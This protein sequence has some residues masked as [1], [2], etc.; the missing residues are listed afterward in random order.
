MP[1]PES[2]SNPEP[3][4]LRPG[5]PPPAP[6]VSVVVPACNAKQWIRDAIDSALGQSYA[7]LQVIVVDDGSTDGTGDVLKERYGDAIEYVG[8]AHGGLSRAR[9]TG[10]I[11]ARGEYVQFLDADD[12][13][14]P[15]KISVQ[16]EAFKEHPECAVVFSDFE[17]FDDGRPD[18][19][20][21]GPEEF[22][23]K[24]RDADTFAGLLT[25]NFILSATPLAR[26]AAVVDAGM[27]DERLSACEDFDL[28]LRI[29]ARGGRF[30]FVDRVLAFIRRRAGSMS[31]ARVRQLS[32]TIEVHRRMGHLGRR[33]TNEQARLARQHESKLHEELAAALR[34]EHREW[35][36]ARHVWSAIGCAPREATRILA[37]TYLGA[38][39]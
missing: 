5:A 7:P 3:E 33:L 32:N 28:W 36:A 38:P 6:L 31:T 9:N 26:K 24:S 27:F 2:A 1:P 25:G 23:R 13:L 16:V 20:R 22:R 18:D 15:D 8:Q 19:R 4:N 30:R 11:R 10:V 39:R 17:E 37:G 12:R 21:P 29:A 14:H 34:R 35:E